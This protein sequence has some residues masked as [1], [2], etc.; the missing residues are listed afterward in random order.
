MRVARGGVAV[1]RGRA[2]L[3]RLRVAKV[4]AMAWARRV[5][6]VCVQ[7]V[8]YGK[9]ACNHN[10]RVTLGQFGRGKKKQIFF[11]PSTIPNT[12]HENSLGQFI[13]LLFSQQQMNP[14]T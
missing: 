4:V 2:L 8:P 10:A 1:G 9:T 7:A 14:F 3:L 5:L 11:W 12:Q 13:I 6:H